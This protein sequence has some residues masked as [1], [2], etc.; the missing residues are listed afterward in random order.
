MENINAYFASK[1]TFIRY[2]LVILISSISLGVLAEAQ[3]PKSI[4]GSWVNS[5][6]NDYQSSQ[7]PRYT[8]EVKEEGTFDIRLENKSDNCN[9][10]PHLFLLDTNGSMISSNDDWGTTQVPQSPDS[11]C[12]YNSR[13]TTSNLSNGIYTLVAGTYSNGESG[14]FVISARSSSGSFDL[15]QIDSKEIKS[16]SSNCSGEWKSSGGRNHKS[17]QNPNFDLIVKEKQKVTI[18]LS[19]SIDTY[20]YLLINDGVKA[21]NDDIRRGNYN[22]RIEQVLDSRK[23]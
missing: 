15:K 17:N 20:L 1:I 4:D 19:S 13:I 9:A 5:G 12:R 3:N 7:N 11:N 14:D 6:G 22:S 23:L 16:I 18:N 2:L 8:F 10:D 21:E